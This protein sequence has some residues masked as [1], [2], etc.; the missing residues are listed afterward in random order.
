MINGVILHVFLDFFSRA[1]DLMTGCYLIYVEGWSVLKEFCPNGWS[2]VKVVIMRVF[3][4]F[5]H[6]HAIS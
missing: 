1:R 3:L 5:F 6:M 2:M 4:D